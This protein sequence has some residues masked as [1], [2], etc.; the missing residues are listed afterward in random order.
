ML[1][2]KLSLQDEPK[3]FD[4]SEEHS[5]APAARRALLSSTAAA[6]QAAGPSAVLGSLFEHLDEPFG[7]CDR[8]FQLCPVLLRNGDR[9]IPLII[10][11]VVV[12]TL[13][14]MVLP[15]P[16]TQSNAIVVSN[17]VLVS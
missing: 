11:S 14:I 8:F 17:G 16:V 6:A 15:V 7:E 2:I 10:K 3:L 1:C 12:Q 4:L 9:E 5:V 13:R